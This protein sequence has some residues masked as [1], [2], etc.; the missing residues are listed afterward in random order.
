MSALGNRGMEA[1]VDEDRRGMALIAHAEN[2][3]DHRARES[4]AEAV[5]IVEG[6]TAPEVG[7][8]ACLALGSYSPEV[9]TATVGHVGSASTVAVRSI[10]QRQVTAARSHTPAVR[11]DR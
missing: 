1:V 7:E 4:V 9:E 5:A 2:A 6:K 10:G 3:T 8:T 11:S